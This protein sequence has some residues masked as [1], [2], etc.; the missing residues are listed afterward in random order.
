M[1]NDKVQ[2]NISYPN[3]RLPFEDVWKVIV[4][5]FKFSNS[6]FRDISG[7]WKRNEDQLCTDQKT[8]KKD[9]LNYPRNPLKGYLNIKSIRNKM[10]DIREGFRKLQLDYFV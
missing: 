2:Q 3:A 6:S 7:I 1:M 9:R 10:S 8:F 4:E 5:I